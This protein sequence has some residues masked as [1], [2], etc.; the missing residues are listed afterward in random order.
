VS[1]L[2]N[3]ATGT[4]LAARVVRPNGWLKRALGLLGRKTLN[5][6]EA[7]W[8]EHCWGIHTVGMRF[9]IDVLFLDQDLRI[10]RVRANVQAGRFAVAHF[11]AY[12]V[13]ELAAGTCEQFD[14]LPG[15]TMAL[16]EATT[17]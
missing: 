10:L 17:Q 15:D 6:D 16:S 8:L 7:L 2:K 3:A 4:V 1:E 11:K 5:A 14:L 9:P 12:H 13:I